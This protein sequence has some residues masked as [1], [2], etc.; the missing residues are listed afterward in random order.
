MPI[1]LEARRER[2]ATPTVT[3]KGGSLSASINKV[4]LPAWI[5]PG[6]SVGN[7]ERRFFTE[8]LALLLE[9]GATL[10][11]GI[12]TLSQQEHSPAMTRVL[13]Q[14]DAD[15]GSGKSFSQALA[16]H[17]GVFSTTYTSLVAASEDGGYMHDVLQQLLQ[18]E[19]KREQLRST[20]VSALSYPMFLS[21]F[22]V[23]VVVFV[24]VV[25][26]PKFG[27]MFASI[28]DQLPATTRG[29][30]WLSDVLRE[31]WVYAVAGVAAA[32]LSFHQWASSDKGREQLDRV[33]LGLPVVKNVFV[34]VYLV[35]SLRVMSLSL[36][37]GVSLTDTLASC[38]EVVEN[39]VFRR[40]FA[41]VETSV[42]QGSG[43]SAGFKEDTILPVLVKQMISTGEE[44][45]N[46][47]KVMAR[48][49]D[50]Y[51]RELTKRLATLS[52]MA[53]PIMLMIMGVVV[54]ILVSSL[55]LPIFKLSRAVS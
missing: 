1:E 35:Q 25:V 24:L 38:K 33:R 31:Y 40:L 19:E 39:R 7:K 22:S 4:E 32:G 21:F 13:A 12:A 51:E 18:M 44:S 46:L 48:L 17:P 14:L 52:K 34:E 49:A 36:A 5:S 8:Q 26:F 50:F 15:I 41:R 55:I 6:Q 45:G 43:I 30:M 54:G 28:Y 20:V 3:E 53:E 23:A 11:Q 47:P 42:Y 10:Q 37:N 2:A 29:L 9:T 27:A 16:K